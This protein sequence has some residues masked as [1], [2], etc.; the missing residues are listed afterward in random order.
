NDFERYP[1]LIGRIGFDDEDALEL[2]TQAVAEMQ[3]RYAQFKAQG[4]RSLPDYNA[5][6]T[7]EARIP[8]WVLV[9]DE[10]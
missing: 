2:L 9:L 3:S 1:H 6:A 7:P 5:K 10:Y 4:V 8:W